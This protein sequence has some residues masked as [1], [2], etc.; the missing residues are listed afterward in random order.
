FIVRGVPQPYNRTQL[1]VLQA[2]LD[3]RWPKLPHEEAKT[4]LA[5]YEGGRSPVQP[6]P[7]PRDQHAAICSRRARVTPRATAVGDLPAHDRRRGLLQRGCAR[8]SQ[9]PPP[10]LGARSSVDEPSAFRRRTL[11]QVQVQSRWRA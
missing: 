4:W 6:S 3:A 7:S 2:T 9:V 5:R 8:A 11:D 10:R 1:R